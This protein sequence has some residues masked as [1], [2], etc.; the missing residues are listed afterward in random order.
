MT[1]EEVDDL[2]GIWSQE[3]FEVEYC[4]FSERVVLRVVKAVV[5][6]TYRGLSRDIR[7]GRYNCWR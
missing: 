4:L 3:G 7:Y 2:E 5:Q 1:L 6:S